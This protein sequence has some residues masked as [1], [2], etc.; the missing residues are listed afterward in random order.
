MM[1]ITERMMNGTASPEDIDLL[2]SVSRQIQNKCLCALGEFSIMAVQSSLQY[3]HPDFEAV[4]TQQPE[5]EVSQPVVSGEQ[6]S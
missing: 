3:F 4:V 2:Q 6:R 1:H 5:E